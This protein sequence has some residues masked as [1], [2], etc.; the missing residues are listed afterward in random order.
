VAAHRPRTALELIRAQQADRPGSAS[1]L[2]QVQLY[3]GG[4]LQGAPGQEIPL[5]PGDPG[6]YERI[7]PPEPEQ[8][9]LDLPPI[10][11]RRS[12]GAA[13]ANSETAPIV[14][15]LEREWLERALNRWLAY[16]SAVPVLNQ[17]DGRA[18]PIIGRNKPGGLVGVLGIQLAAAYVGGR[19][20][21]WCGGAYAPERHPPART[22]HFCSPEC[23]DQ[24]TLE[25]K[26][27]SWRKHAAEWSNRE[28]GQ[29]Q[30]R[31]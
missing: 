24:A 23:A 18:V 11:T 28:P 12:T 17:I 8:S 7:P 19:I 3:A 26:R 9:P 25:R 31:D 27:R 13:T 2:R 14:L 15:D 29:E 21:S 4:Q 1:G 5:G 20:C 22:R 30:P 16:G 10:P 6:Y